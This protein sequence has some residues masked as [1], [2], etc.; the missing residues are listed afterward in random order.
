MILNEVRNY[1]AKIFKTGVNFDNLA[2]TITKKIEDNFG[3]KVVEVF[4][5]TQDSLVIDMGVEII[6]ITALQKKDN[7]SFTDYFKDSFSILRPDFEIAY[8]TGVKNLFNKE[9]VITVLGQRKLDMKSTSYA[10]LARL[11]CDLRDEGYV[12]NDI[13]LQNVGKDNNR[14]YLIDYGDVFNR[15]Y[16]NDYNKKLDFNANVYPYYNEIYDKILMIRKSVYDLDKRKKV[17]N[18]YLESVGKKLEHYYRKLDKKREHMR[19]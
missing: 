14:A 5:G 9:I 7:F 18:R 16:E 17:T 12:W 2:L 13:K 15:R 6:K 11:Y 3:D 19:F 8:H 10:D 4:S 1:L